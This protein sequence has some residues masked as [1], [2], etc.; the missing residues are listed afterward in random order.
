MAVGCGDCYAQNGTLLCSRHPWRRE[1]FVFIACAV[2]T[3]T[4]FT[5]SVMEFPS[6]LHILYSINSP[7]KSTYSDI[8]WIEYIP[9]RRT[10]PN[11]GTDIY[12]K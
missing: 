11:V 6:A 3:V 10:A 1:I 8:A 12:R 5:Q 7:A 2:L 9:I 4:F